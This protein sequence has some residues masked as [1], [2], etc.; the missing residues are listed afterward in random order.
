[1]ADNTA[2]TIEA[3]AFRI[4]GGALVLLLPAGCAAAY[5]AGTWLTIEEATP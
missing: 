2:R 3:R 1:M 5:A 4:D